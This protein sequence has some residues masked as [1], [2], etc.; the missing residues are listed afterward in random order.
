M[1]CDY[2]IGNHGLV[3]SQNVPSLERDVMLRVHAKALQNS[4]GRNRLF[5]T[6]SQYRI[7]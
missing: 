6:A 4:M 7:V 1:L 3:T 5:R 2:L